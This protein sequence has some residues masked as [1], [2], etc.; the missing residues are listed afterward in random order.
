MGAL[1]AGHRVAVQAPLAAAAE[2]RRPRSARLGLQTLPGA[3]R[4]VK[5]DGHRRRSTPF[6]GRDGPPTLP[7]GMV[8]GMLPVALSTMVPTFPRVG[9]PRTASL[10]RGERHIR[11]IAY[12]N[13]SP[14]ASR[15]LCSVLLI[16]L[17]NME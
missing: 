11:A 1:P 16:L 10:P 14:S 7:G 5:G 3:L 13:A 8:S 6:T 2:A 15:G 17:I 4:A 9:A 12:R